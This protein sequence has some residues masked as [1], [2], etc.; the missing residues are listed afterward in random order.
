MKKGDPKSE[1]YVRAVER[2]GAEAVW[3]SKGATSWGEQLTTIDGLLLTGG[4]DVAPERY[5]D[6]DGGKNEL[7]DRQRDEAELEAFD[8]C[9]ELGL[10]VLGI[11]RGFQVINV[12]MGGKLVQDVESDLTE[13]LPHRSLNDV[14]RKH[15]VD[16]LPD[17]L[18][19]GILDRSGEMSVNSRHHQAVTREKLAPG[20]KASAIAPDGVVE[21]IEAEGDHFV[22]GVQCHPERDGEAEAMVPVFAALVEEARKD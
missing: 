15:T 7:V 12:A 4:G 11:C 16:V 10:P 2:A 18:L 3:L 20:L 6:T 17:T 9:W 14:S 8:Y 5:D 19:A 22:V 21:G 1:N 13:A